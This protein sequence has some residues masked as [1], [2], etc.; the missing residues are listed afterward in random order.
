MNLMPMLKHTM[1][2]RDQGL[3]LEGINAEM[4][5]VRQALLGNGGPSMHTRV[6]DEGRVW[7]RDPQVLGSA[8]LKNKLN[9]AARDPVWLPT[10]CRAPTEEVAKAHAEMNV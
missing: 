2:W 5:S 10:V 8:G 9:K 3:S 1:Y 4:G 6:G 7:P